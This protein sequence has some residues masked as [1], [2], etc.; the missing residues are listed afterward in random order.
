[1]KK[2]RKRKRSTELQERT[3]V[4]LDDNVTN[5]LKQV[6]EM[7][8]WPWARALGFL[9]LAGTDAI[10]QHGKGLSALR[11]VI[12]AATEKHAAELQA[13]KMVNARTAD[14]REATKRLNRVQASSLPKLTRN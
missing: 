10:Y 13:A 3:T 5:V 11:G 7:T 4:R 9:A 1:M 12:V 14:L 8:G 6:Q 2:S